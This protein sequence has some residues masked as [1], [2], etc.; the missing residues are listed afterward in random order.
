MKNSEIGVTTTKQEFV[1][2]LNSVRGGQFFIIK[3]YTNSQNEGSSDHILRFG[4]KYDNIKNRDISF[5]KTAIASNACI[6]VKGLPM[7]RGS[8]NS[9]NAEV[10]TTEGV[11]ESLP[12]YHFEV[13]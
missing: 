5:V 8:L 7:G 4:I 1:D 12:Q 9:L 6:S 10:M 13:D 2:Y 3:G 11:N